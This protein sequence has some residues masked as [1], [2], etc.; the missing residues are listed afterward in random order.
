MNLPIACTL[1]PTD[2]ARRVEEYAALAR[3]ALRSREP[4]AH[5]ERLTFD[6]DAGTEREL[7]AAI[8]AESRCCAFLEMRL[9][10][11]GDALVLDVTGPDEAGPVVEQLFAPT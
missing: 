7:L 10:R 9:R 3:R 5:G 6:G 2:Q 8:D 1:S 11:E 4:I